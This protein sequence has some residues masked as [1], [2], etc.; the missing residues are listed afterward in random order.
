MIIKQTYVRNILKTNK[1]KEEN[2]K[3]REI[4]DQKLNK[5]RRE[6]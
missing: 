3:K 5:T 2:I 4:F 6:I 1:D